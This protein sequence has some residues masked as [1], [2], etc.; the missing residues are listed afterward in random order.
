MITA[1]AQT[2]GAA[3]LA[4]DSGRG[5]EGHAKSDDKLAE[6]LHLGNRDR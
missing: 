2:L 6:D 5:E 3:F 1:F 4:S